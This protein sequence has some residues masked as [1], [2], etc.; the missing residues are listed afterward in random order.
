[1]KKKK[2]IFNLHVKPLL[3]CTAVV[4]PQ[5]VEPPGAR[6]A[7]PKVLRRHLHD[8]QEPFRPRTGHGPEHVLLHGN[9]PREK[10][11][12]GSLDLHCRQSVPDTHIAATD[13]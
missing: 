3:V 12:N 4:R 6:R 10:P 5:L 9:A 1:M 13:L 7:V 8:R 2:R 11:S